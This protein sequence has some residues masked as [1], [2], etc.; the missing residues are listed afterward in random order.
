M[1]NTLQ[2]GNK[3]DKTQSSWS[4]ASGCH[5]LSWLRGSTILCKNFFFFFFLRERERENIYLTILVGQVGDRDSAP[6]ACCGHA[7]PPLLYLFCT[8]PVVLSSI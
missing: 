2:D 3:A 6:E 4:M 7:V 1:R 5:P 8:K